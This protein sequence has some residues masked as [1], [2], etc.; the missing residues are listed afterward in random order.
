MRKRA[1]DMLS[2]VTRDQLLFSK[3]ADAPRVSKAHRVVF[4]TT[5]GKEFRVISSI[6]KKYLPIC[7][8]LI[9]PF[10]QF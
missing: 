1:P 4:S 9:H 2:N 5:Y 6:I 7:Y 8:T 3:E 10:L